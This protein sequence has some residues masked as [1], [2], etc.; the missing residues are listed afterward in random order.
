MKYKILCVFLFSALTLLSQSDTLKQE[1]QT[2]VI[3]DKRIQLEYSEV[4]RNITIVDKATIQN[5]AAF[6]AL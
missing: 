1:I 4:S 2:V 5:S 6:N 3:S